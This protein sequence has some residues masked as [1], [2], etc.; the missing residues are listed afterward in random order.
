MQLAQDKIDQADLVTGILNATIHGVFALEAVRN[1]EGCIVDFR[2]LKVNDHFAAMLELQEAEI[3][4]KSYLSILPHS[5]TNGLFD[6]KCKVVNEGKT[7][8]TEL[9]YESVDKWL[10]ISISRLGTNGV[11]ETVTDITATKR[12]KQEIER[13]AQKL[14]TIISTSQSGVHIFKPEYNSDGAIMDFR[15]VL[16]NQ[17]VASYI[18]QTVNDLIGALAS[19]YFPAYMQN[20]LFEIYRD[21]FLTGESKQFDF[22]YEDGYDVFFNLLVVKLGDELMVTLTDHTML[23]R[24]QRELEASIAELKRSNASLEQFAHAASH[25]L[26]EPLRKIIVNSERLLHEFD[27]DMNDNAYGIVERIRTAGKRMHRLVQDLLV[28]AEVGANKNRF[29]TVNLDALVSEVVND[30]EVAM[31]ERDAAVHAEALGTLTGDPLH[32]QQL[33]QNLLSNSLK[34]SRLG[35]P[36]LIQLTATTMPGYQTGLP[37]ADTELQQTFRVIQLQDNGQG[38]TDDEAQQIFKIFQRLP[39]HRQEYA[40]T[41]IGLAIVQRVV[42]NHKGYITA[43]GIE[44]SGATFKV[45]FPIT[46]TPS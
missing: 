26:Q 36:P 5:S 25:D 24:L 39:K 46:L 37:L 8:S 12:D 31:T 43:S 9:Y 28:F 11:V 4:G 20:G 33:F 6:L 42:E 10:H 2:F 23:K 14:N 30:L 16:V 34:Y 7:V 41:G 21:V 32:L 29:E 27:A 40:G 15:M 1:E 45:Y 44:G 17:T 22:H 35:V 13:S 3:I 38:F 18:G 19:T